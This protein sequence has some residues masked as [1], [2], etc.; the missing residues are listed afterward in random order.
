MGGFCATLPGL[1][2]HMCHSKNRAFRTNRM[3][4]SERRGDDRGRPGRTRRAGRRGLAPA[5]SLLRRPGSYQPAGHAIAGPHGLDP[6][7]GV[8]RR[9]LG[10][11]TVPVT[12]GP[13]GELFLGP[14][15]PAARPYAAPARAHPAVRPGQEPRRPAAPATSRCRSGWWSSS[16]APTG[17][18]RRCC[19]PTGCSTS[20]CATTPRCSAAA[21]AASS[22][23]ARSPCRWPASST[24]ASCS[25]PR[26][27]GTR[28]PTARFDDLGSPPA[29]PALVPMISEPWTPPVRLGRPRADPGRGAA[30]AARAWCARPTRTAVR[31]GSPA[32]RDGSRPGPRGRSG[33]SWAPPGST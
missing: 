31:C 7:P 5:P 18:P 1:R 15:A 27:C 21:T 13:H 3:V 23:R 11:L 2:R 8:L 16:P 12:P 29:P 20:S 30:P 19:A 9:G 32:C 26:P 4:G 17:T 14:G 33:P 6:L 22:C 28:S 24:S 25:P 10:G